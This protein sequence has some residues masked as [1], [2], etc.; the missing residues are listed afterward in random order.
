MTTSP[1]LPVTVIR[2]RRTKGLVDWSE[3]WAYRDLVYFLTWRD[4]KVRYKQTA[5]GAAWA[6]LQP[7]LTMVV[8]SI[9]FGR[10]AGIDSGNVP[11]PVFAY[12][13]LVPWTFFANAVTQASNSLVQQESILTKVYFPRVIVPSAAVLAGLVDIT[14]AFSVLVAMMLAF[15]IVPTVAVMTLPLLV[16]FAAMTAFAVGLWLSALNVRYRDVR[17][18][19]P[20]IVQVWLFASPVAYPSSLVPEALRPLYGINPMVGVIDGFRWALLGDVEAPGWSFLVSVGV[21]IAL[22]VGGLAYFR[23]MERSFADAV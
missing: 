4:I 14:V 1:A 5:L 12:T 17:Y 23:R 22:L 10:L 3:L 19:L 13:A 2:A 20:F 11:Y 16:A 6:V 7:F 8:F 15:G 18:T 9:F 21:V